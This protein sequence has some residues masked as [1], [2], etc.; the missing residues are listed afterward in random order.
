M[1]D[2][3][4]P[5]QR[6]LDLLPA[7]VIARDAASGGLL[8]ALAEAVGGELDVL[9]RDIDTLYA[10]WFIETCP[11]WVVPYIADL[12]GVDD[13]PPDLSATAGVAGTS[14]RAFV[15]N[16]V[17]YRR[18]KGTL[19]AIEQVARDAGG[20]PARAVEFYRLLS[21]SAH[22]NHPRPDRPGSADLRTPPAAAGALD[23]GPTT[24]AQ[25]ALDSLPHVAEVRHIAR[26]RG[27]FGI[28][29]VGAFLFPDQVY[30]AVRVPARPPDTD[31]GAPTGWAVHPLG[32]PAPMY[33][34]PP[35]DDT[36]EHLAGESDLPVPLRPRLLLALL[37]AA[38][39]P[40]GENA[41]L[42]VAVS[43]GAGGPLGA[44]RIRVCGLEDLAPDP[45]SP[46]PAHPRPLRGWQVLVDPVSGRLHPYLDGAPGT[47][48]DLSVSHSYG[49][50]ADVGAG[51]YDRS[52]V[53][54]DVLATDRYRGDPARGGPDAVA[55][56]AVTGG[57]ASALQ[58]ALDDA[59][60]TWAAG[61][62]TGAGYVVSIGDSGRYSGDLTVHVPEATRLIVVAAEWEPRLSALGE[63]LDRLPGRYAPGGLRPHLKGKLTVTGGGG[64]SVVLDGLTI[65]GDVVVG[66]GELGSLTVSQCTIAGQVLV[67][68]AEPTNVGIDVRVVR[69]TCRSVQFGRAA[70]TLAIADSVVD[71]LD[72]F[73]AGSGDPPPA[74]SGPGLD[75]AVT[76]STIRGPVRARTLQAS[77][78]IFDGPV[79]VE[80]RQEGCV[81]FSYLHPAS[82]VPR[83]YRCVPG[84]GAAAGVRP[85]YVSDS[86]G[87]PHYLA[88]A[89]GCPVAIATGAEGGAEMGVHHHL[90]RPPRV[91]AVARLLA[92]YV[93]V[94]LEIGVAAPV[95]TVRS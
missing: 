34:T 69:S 42:P 78:A 65:E 36:V 81:R 93:P 27:R 91:A 24:V 82:R 20:W 60:D 12:V 57:G 21:T 7:H 15:A 47:P 59:R 16:T 1:S 70:A 9:E 61:E 72:G 25:G 63:P 18:R 95:A 11:E 19:A 85:V 2:P 40:A 67:G 76:A 50:T 71:A 6:V 53:H 54:A 73:D 62:S 8:A 88:L 49:G 86:P 52:P 74:V 80:H 38:R 5:E 41:S 94:G 28:P 43:V 31:P 89:S 79:A 4:P 58:D 3:R 22:V 68:T 90:Q 55:Q 87:S 14:R 75:L 44:E 84:P 10:S 83:R 66:V 92:P 37:R 33:L 46:D 29:A 45:G 35:D 26:G 13:L 48:G 77:S 64:S 32:L 30:R 56:T 39:S 51:S 23:L 17:A